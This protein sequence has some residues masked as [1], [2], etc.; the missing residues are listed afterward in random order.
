MLNA[1]GRAAGRAAERLIGVALLPVTVP[2][3][4]LAER[5]P[6]L[7]DTLPAHLLELAEG[8]DDAS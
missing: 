8:D 2:I 7:E 1:L 6:S 3:S 4:L 5:L